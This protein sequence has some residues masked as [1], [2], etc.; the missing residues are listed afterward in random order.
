MGINIMVFCRNCGGGLPSEY[1]SFCPGCGKSQNNAS[2]VTMAAQPKNSG[3][4]IVIALIVGILGFNGIGHMY[5]GKIGRGIFLLI[6]GWLI[7]ALTFV[8]IPF[9]IIYIVFWLWQV[10]DVNVKTKY[11][12][13]YI[14]SNGK[15]PW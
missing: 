4:A 5:I 9:G 15:S 11:Y 8:F 14:M 13:D 3:T 7:L 12:N 10:Y 6:V 1:S 2:T